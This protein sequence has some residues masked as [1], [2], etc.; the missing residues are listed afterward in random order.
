MAGIGDIDLSKMFDS[1]SS[2][3]GDDSNPIKAIYDIVPTYDSEQ[4]KM[5]FMYQF[6]IDK[7]ELTHLQSMFDHFDSILSNNKNLSFFGSKNLQNMLGAYT[8]T[9][10]VRGI[11]IRSKEPNEGQVV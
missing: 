9:E 10:L 1:M 5:L 4:Q 8:Q 2:N 11:N 6:M 7:W 3:I